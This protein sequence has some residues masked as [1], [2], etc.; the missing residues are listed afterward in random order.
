MNYA[1]P[2]VERNQMHSVLEQI[3]SLAAASPL[4]YAVLTVTVTTAVALTLGYVMDRLGRALGLDTSRR[5]YTQDRVS[6]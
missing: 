4:L 1:T 3:N 6:R 2:T 5:K